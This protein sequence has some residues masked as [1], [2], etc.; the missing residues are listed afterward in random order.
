M[1]FDLS[2]RAVC[3]L[4]SHQPGDCR[5]DSFIINLN[6]KTVEAPGVNFPCLNLVPFVSSSKP[7]SN[8]HKDRLKQAP[9]MLRFPST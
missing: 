7:H 1:G 9:A 2:P 6:Q 4:K 5:E 8:S 3:G